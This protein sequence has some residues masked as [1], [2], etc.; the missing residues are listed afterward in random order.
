MSF[1]EEEENIIKDFIEINFNLAIDLGRYRHI[2]D[3]LPLTEEEEEKK[4]KISE[5]KTRLSNMDLSGLNLRSEVAGKSALDYADLI[6][7]KISEMD[8]KGRSFWDPRKLYNSLFVVI[9]SPDLNDE[10]R[11]NLLRKLIEKIP[12]Y[13]DTEISCNSEIILR[14]AL[15]ECEKLE[16]LLGSLREILEK[17]SLDTNLKGELNEERKSAMKVI[18]EYRK[19]LKK[20]SPDLPLVPIGEDL[21]NHLFQLEGVDCNVSGLEKRAKNLLRNSRRRMREQ[22]D[23]MGGGDGVSGSLKHINNQPPYERNGMENWYKKAASKG[24]E[25]LIERILMDVPKD[26]EVKI[27]FNERSGWNRQPKI[28]Y[29]PSPRLRNS[30]KALASIIFDKSGVEN[31]NWLSHWQ[32]QLQTMKEFYPG[33]HMIYCRQSIE[34]HPLFALSKSLPILGG[35]SLYAPELMER[36]EFKEAPEMRFVRAKSIYDEASLTIAGLKLAGGQMDFEDSLSYLID[37]TGKSS[38]EAIDELVYSVLRPSRL[39]Y[40]RG[41]E[42][43]EELKEEVEWEMGGGFSDRYFHN[44]VTDKGPLRY[45]SLREL[46][47]AEAKGAADSHRGE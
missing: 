37:S 28:R 18:S 6:Q 38:R 36:Y 14:K 47:L 25:Y 5:I 23:E 12:G 27:V 20:H 13:L 33:V 1:R 17:T 3:T 22:A 30:E 2:I 24:K 11:N 9:Y 35:W 7:F 21:L 16:T 29:Y 4:A 19:N 31:E 15:E 39:L 46:V 26:E 42:L 43:L 8:E 10:T 45:D 44:T 34:D 32:I 40:L 41:R